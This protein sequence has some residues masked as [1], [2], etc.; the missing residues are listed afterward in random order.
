MQL[1]LSTPGLGRILASVVAAEIEDIERFPN[2]AKLC[3]Y[4]GLVATTK[5]SV[6]QVYHGKMLQGCNK[7]MRWAMIEAAWVAV[8]CD[9][10]LGSLYRH[11]RER[12]KKA[13]TAISIVA[14]RMCQIIWN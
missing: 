12:G 13:N 10:Y 14:R 7:W 2:S 11:H 5:A 3:A 6:G 8:G 1:L 9:S 4:A